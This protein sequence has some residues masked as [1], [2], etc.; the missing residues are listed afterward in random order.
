MKESIEH[1]RLAHAVQSRAVAV[2]RA[3]AGRAVEVPPEAVFIEPRHNAAMQEHIDE[4]KVGVRSSKLEN[5]VEQNPEATAHRI[6]GMVI[7][8]QKRQ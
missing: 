4:V 8:A 6:D 7:Q 2:A 3:K 5:F 1:W